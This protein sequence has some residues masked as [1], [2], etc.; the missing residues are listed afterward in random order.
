MS[1]LTFGLTVAMVGAGGTM[2]VL[3]L[4]SVVILLIRKVFPYRAEDAVPQ[5][6]A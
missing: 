5:K 3:W 6:G 4:I 2:I 1:D